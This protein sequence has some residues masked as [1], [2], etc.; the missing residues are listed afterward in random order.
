MIETTSG[1]ILTA[2]AEALV[3][4]VNCVGIM[5][6]GIALQFRKAFPD[7]F[8]AYEAVCK[9]GELHPGHMFI[10]DTGSL[11]NPRYI[12]NFPTKRHWKGKSRLADI[13]TGLTALM[14]DIR[15]LGIHSIA[16]PPLGCGQGG[17]DWAEV[18]PRIERAL[19]AVPDVRV[20]LFNPTGTPASVTST[21]SHP[22]PKMTAARAALVGLMQRYL[23]GLMDPFI[24][25]LEVHKLLYFMQERGESSLRLRYVKAPYGPYAENLRHLLMNVEGYLT[26]GYMVLM[27]LKSHWSWCLALLKKPVSS[28][29]H[30]RIR[31]SG[32]SE[33]LTW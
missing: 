31:N 5:G 16:I 28:W 20:L 12:I 18:R 26:S 29:P 22:V 13:E 10:F 23:G 14:T 11:T 27:T 4:T 17:L 25:L 33:S 15:R 19:A 2:D 1:D 6:R 7:N 3:N 24:S 30:I 32:L 21:A 8:K 9:R